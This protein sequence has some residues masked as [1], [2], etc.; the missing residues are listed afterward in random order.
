MQVETRSAARLL[1]CARV[2]LRAGAIV[3]LLCVAD[4]AAMPVAAQ[5]LPTPLPP[6]VAPPC[7]QRYPRWTG[8]ATS[9]GVNALLGGISA[10]VLRELRGGSFRDGFFRGAVG[11]SMIY[12]SKRVVAGE[13]DG[14]G[15]IGR[16]LG[17]VGASV[18]RNA[19]EGRGM[20]EE[21]VLPIGPSRL[22]VNTQRGA[23]RLVPDLT[24]IAWTISGIVEPELRLDWRESLSSGTPVFFAD[25]RI[26]IISADSNHVGGLT[27][28]GVI[29]LANVPAFGP[30]VARINLKHE[31]VHV[32]QEDQVF[33]TI[34]DPF[35]DWVV[36]KL[37]YAGGFLVKHV[38]INLAT[39]LFEVIGGWL[40]EF[41]DRPWETEAVFRA[42]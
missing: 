26:I 1:R 20:F 38:D 24:A 36:G 28:S 27:N 25:D 32:V 7:N 5:C 22:Y 39:S 17:A 14:A 2:A 9:L 10:G 18:V 37:P 29:M 4:A 30:D 42:R 33:L 16:E 12:V 35:E 6:E 40:P 21:L 13:F 11:G 8:E 15:L 34:T 31:R 41:L 19:G 23:V 3:A